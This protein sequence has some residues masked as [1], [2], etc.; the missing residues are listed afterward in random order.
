M[1]RRAIAVAVISAAALTGCAS[2]PSPEPPP[3]VAVPAPMPA[4]ARQPVAI[5]DD[6]RKPTT[7][8]STL[9]SLGSL[10]RDIEVAPDPDAAVDA[11]SAALVL[12]RDSPSVH[13]AYLRRMVDLGLPQLA[14]SAADRLL[15]DEP[16]N[17]LARA[18]LANYEASQGNFSDALT[19]ISLAV[20][21]APDEPFVQVTAAHLLAWYDNNPN[22]PLLE[23][24][25]RRALSQAHVTLADK[26]AFTTEFD[27]ASNYY[28][29]ARQ[30]EEATAARPSAPTQP[31]AVAEDESPAPTPPPPVADDTDGPAY[32]GGGA[33]YVPYAPGYAPP[34]P[35]VAYYD[36]GLYSYGYVEPWWWYSPG[37][38]VVDRFGHRHHE[39][40]RDHRH[41]GHHG[42]HVD[43]GFRDRYFG[44]G[45]GGTR[46]AGGGSNFGG[47]TY[48]G[49][50]RNVGGTALDARQLDTLRNR[51]NGFDQIGAAVRSG[52]RGSMISP[53]GVTLGT[54]NFRGLPPNDSRLRPGSSFVNNNRLG[55]IP[56]PLSTI[57]GPLANIPGPLSNI[58]GRLSTIP[59]PLSNIPRPLSNTPPIGVPPSIQGSFPQVP[60]I[61]VA[62]TPPF[63]GSPPSAPPVRGG[64]GGGGRGGGGGGRR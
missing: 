30:R 53:G 20:P 14:V 15:A 47:R 57:P 37:F 17:A 16:N 48:Y 50:N 43:D 6:A 19:D 35:A 54:S 52:N 55:T 7:K 13:G 64:G 22:A 40:D 1:S 51:V 26:P 61:I 9:P 3:T 33:V 21:R 29:E 31:T 27:D 45:G 46:V 49:S 8:P 59:G 36:Q 18:V 32:V 25:I 2:S 58:P 38:I 56:G 42:H 5:T 63:V 10:I 41:D 4:T 24:Y 23:S 39:H 60:I 11:Y 44:H 28:R 62:P 34:E 12:H